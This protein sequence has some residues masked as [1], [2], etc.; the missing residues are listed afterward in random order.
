MYNTFSSYPAKYHKMFVVITAL[1]C[2][3]VTHKVQNNIRYNSVWVYLSYTLIFCW[4]IRFCWL[5]QIRRITLHVEQMACPVS[6]F[7]SSK[8]WART[9][10]LA[11]Y[12]GRFASPEPWFLRSTAGLMHL[13]HQCSDTDMN[14]DGHGKVLSTSNRGLDLNFSMWDKRSYPDLLEDDGAESK[15]S[16]FK[17]EIDRESPCLRPS[18]CKRPGLLIGK[19]NT[20]NNPACTIVLFCFLCIT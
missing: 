15:V 5:L 1:F 12:I 4:P 7:H 13:L 8:L 16:P 19:G 18:G 6:L 20:F 2:L 17:H 9:W 11:S 10:F 14:F 3:I